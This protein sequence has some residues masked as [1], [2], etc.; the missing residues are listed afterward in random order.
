[1]LGSQLKNPNQIQSR[2]MF[3]RGK[4][5]DFDEIKEQLFEKFIYIFTFIWLVLKN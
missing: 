4:K 3:V 2:S 1:M 5:K